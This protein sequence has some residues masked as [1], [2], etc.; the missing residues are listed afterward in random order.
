MLQRLKVLFR[1][2]VKSRSAC[3]S[4][5]HVVVEHCQKLMLRNG[6][7]TLL[8]YHMLSTPHSVL[9]VAVNN[10]SCLVVAHG[11]VNNQSVV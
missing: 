6:D 3:R 8:T 5:V 10:L 1:T 11:V 4:A 9:F 2:V 7:C